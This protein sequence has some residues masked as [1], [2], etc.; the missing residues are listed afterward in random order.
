MSDHS[1]VEIV[2]PL[3]WKMK[4]RREGRDARRFYNKGNRHSQLNIDVNFKNKL[5]MMFYFIFVFLVCF[6]RIG[7]MV[8]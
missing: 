8:T 1:D 6:Y 3:G 4:N 5:I 7:E 2:A